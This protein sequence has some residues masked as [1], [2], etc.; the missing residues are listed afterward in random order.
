MV[1]VTGANAAVTLTASYG[2]VSTGSNATDIQ[3]DDL[4]YFTIDTI[5]SPQTAGS[6]FSITLTAKDQYGNTLD[7]DTGVN[8]FEGVGNTVDLTVTS[9]LVTVEATGTGTT[10]TFTDGGWTGNVSVDEAQTNA[11]LTATDT[12]PGGLGDGSQ[13]G[14]SNTFDVDP[15]V[16]LISGG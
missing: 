15:F 16:V 13:T 10:G 3:P 8:N 14:S 9:G 1:T 12:D 2:G 11:E 7:T 6:N 5:G 4:S